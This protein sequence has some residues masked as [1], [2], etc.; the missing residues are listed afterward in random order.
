MDDI[1]DVR[2]VLKGFSS[3]KW[4]KLGR[5]LRIDEQHL[6]TIG[7]NNLI[8]GGTEECLD[9]VLQT[10][11]KRNYNDNKYGLPTWKYLADAVE[12]SG[13]KALA[14]NVRKNST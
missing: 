1:H 5:G 7:A 13:E 2:P 9:Q 3:T 10:W 4:K 14:D 12:E 11:L 8:Q 6:T